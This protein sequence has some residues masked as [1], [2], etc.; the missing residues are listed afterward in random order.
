MY[1]RL[2]T[3]FGKF[4]FRFLVTLHYFLYDGLHFQGKTGKTFFVTSLAK[5]NKKRKWDG[6]LSKYDLSNIWAPLWKG[7][8]TFFAATTRPLLIR[9]Q[10]P[11]FNAK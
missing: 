6:K 8:Q 11:I 5:T 1:A 2:I 7:W 9:Q 10:K 3:N 4:L